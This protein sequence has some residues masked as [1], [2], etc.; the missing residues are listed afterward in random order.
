MLELLTGVLEAFQFGNLLA[1]LSGVVIGIILG[2]IPGIGASAALAMFLPVTFTLPVEQSILL[3]I[4]IYGGAEYGGSISAIAINAPGTGG[5]AATLLDGYPLNQKGLA[6]K[7]LDTSL[8]ASVCGGI[9]SAIVLA[10]FSPPLAKIG[11]KFGPAEMF[12]LTLCGL[13]I[14]ATFASKNVIKGLMAALMGLFIATIGIDPFVG[15]GRYTFDNPAL[16]NG[17]REIPVMIGLFA[18]AEAFRIIEKMGIKGNQNNNIQKQSFTNVKLSL[19]EFLT[20]PKTII[21]S[22]IIGT[23]IGIVPGVGAS[24]ASFISYDFERKV[25][26][27]PEKFGEGCIEGVAAPEAANNAVVGGALIP[28]LSLGI[29]GS[30]ALAVLMG[31][32]IMQGITPGPFLFSDE[33]KLVYLIFGGYF[34]SNIILLIVGYFGV[35]LVLQILKVPERILAP[36]IIAITFLGAY[37]YSY[38]YSDMVIMF[39][40]GVIGWLFKKMDIPIVPMVIAIV[41]GNMVERNFLSALLISKGDPSTFITKPISAFFLLAAILTVVLAFRKPNIKTGQNLSTPT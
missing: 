24:V 17:I 14:I 3:L 15:F 2:A 8:Y 26:K 22:S 4:S 30:A 19:K 16:M 1:I 28:A 33:P 38:S 23:I 35:R 29:P 12:S 5:A 32:L 31:A 21:R 37:V 25:S 9:F 40:F 27:S 6:G 36:C 11:L 34:V 18:L 10:L 20:L 41:L 39:V 7:A 13:A